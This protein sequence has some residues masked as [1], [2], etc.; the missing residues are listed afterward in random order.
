MTQSKGMLYELCTACK[1]TGK[2]LVKH[3]TLE[4]VLDCMLCKP[5]R[6]VETGL[7]LG[8]VDRLVKESQEAV[9]ETFQKR[10]VSKPGAAIEV[11][12][13]TMPER[14]KKAI[15]DNLGKDR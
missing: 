15:A 4:K 2:V 12:E 9:K 5:L 14:I 13:I 6:V 7:T 1:G 10:I 11:T 8:Q 3:E